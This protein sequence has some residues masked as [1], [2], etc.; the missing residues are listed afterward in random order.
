MATVL[1]ESKP[2]PEEFYIPCEFLF[3]YNKSNGILAHDSYPVFV[4]ELLG[5]RVT[6]KVRHRILECKSGWEALKVLQQVGFK[7]TCAPPRR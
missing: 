5:D 7:Y 1:T 3:Y 6:E 4:A 2:D